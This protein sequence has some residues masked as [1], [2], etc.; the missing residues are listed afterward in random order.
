MKTGIQQLNLTLIRWLLGRTLS[1]LSQNHNINDGHCREP[2]PL[3]KRWF[4]S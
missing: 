2:L 3:T 1:L 4:V